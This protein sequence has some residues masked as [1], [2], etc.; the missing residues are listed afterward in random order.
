[1]PETLTFLS[2]S[3]IVIENQSVTCYTV[4]ILNRQLQPKR[5]NIMAQLI[6]ASKTIIAPKLRGTVI[7]YPRKAGAKSAVLRVAGRP[8]IELNDRNILSV[9]ASTGHAFLAVGQGDYVESYQGRF[10]SDSQ[11]FDHVTF[12]NMIE[13]LVDQSVEIV[14]TSIEMD[15]ALFNASDSING[16]DS[17]KIVPG[18]GN[19]SAVLV[20]TQDHQMI[21]PNCHVDA[22]IQLE[23]GKVSRRLDEVITTKSNNMYVRKLVQTES[24]GISVFTSGIRSMSQHHRSLTDLVRSARSTRAF[25]QVVSRLSASEPRL[26]ALLNHTGYPEAREVTQVYNQF[27][28]E[29]VSGSSYIKSIDPKA[30]ELVC[31]LFDQA[32]GHAPV[33]DLH[34]HAGNLLAECGS[35]EQAEAA[36]TEE[37][38][39]L[40]HT[41]ENELQLAYKKLDDEIANSAQL[42]NQIAAQ[43]KENE[44]QAKQIVS[45]ER[46]VVSLQ[47]DIE[48][49]NSE[50][51]DRES[52]Q[53]LQMILTRFSESRDLPKL[54]KRMP[55]MTAKE[56]I[57]AILVC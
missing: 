4:S 27:K 52:L 26:Y 31:V 14:L 9:R 48:A 37:K 53:M 20:R 54:M 35:I 39:D 17:M 32:T 57:S 22:S 45:L 47:D 8:E 21:F 16:P 49:F 19:S 29:D 6:I 43:A 40:L 46:R 55:K 51:L 13:K 11:A 36:L 42:R 5:E 24:S 33:T 18:V 38:K 2:V 44:A 25:N 28:S 41:M 15:F 3:K 34:D 1:M 12:D 50:A 56:L 7:V 10:D 23:R 30:S